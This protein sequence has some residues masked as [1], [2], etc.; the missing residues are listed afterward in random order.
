MKVRFFG[1]VMFL[2]SMVLAAGIV[3]AADVPLNLT[4][5]YVDGIGINV[6]ES[7]T[8]DADNNNTLVCRQENSV[9]LLDMEKGRDLEIRVKLEAHEDQDNVRVEASIK[10]YEYNDKDKTSDETHLFDIEENVTYLKNLELEI[11]ARMDNDDYKL[12]ITIKDRDDN[13][14]LY[15]FDIRISPARHLLQ[16]KDVVMSPAHGVKAGKM[17][18]TSI[19]I[20]NIGAKDEESVKVSISVPELG[21][22]GSAYVDIIEADETESSEEIWLRVPECTEDGFY[23]AEIKVSYDEGYE[24]ITGI[25]ILAVTGE[26]CEAAVEAEEVL[27]QAGGVLIES[28]ESET[29]EISEEGEQKLRHVLEVALIALIIALVIVGAV[30]GFMHFAKEKEF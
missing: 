13:L 14:K 6:E 3:S 4:K 27:V 19:R 8:L 10:G 16:I 21:I 11:P 17:F 24:E 5:V 18:Q 7:C 25:K 23:E 9:E 20:K 26:S 28:A 29:S 22:S 2:V 15:Y 1:I 12:W 30:V